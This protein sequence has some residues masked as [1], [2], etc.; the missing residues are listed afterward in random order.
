[1][2]LTTLVAGACRSSGRSFDALN[3]AACGNSGAGEIL[4][5]LVVCIGRHD[6]H[7]VVIENVVELS[8]EL[9]FDSLGDMKVLA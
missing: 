1:L 3:V 5:R 4:Q 7:V 8:K 2:D 9:S 6:I